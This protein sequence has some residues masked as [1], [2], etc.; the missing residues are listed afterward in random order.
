MQLFFTQLGLKVMHL[1]ARLLDVLRYFPLRLKR[2]FRH[3]IAGLQQLMVPEKWRSRSI[4]FWWIELCLLLLDLLGLSEYY[5]GISSFLKWST[6]PLRPEELKYAQS[7]YG[8]SIRWER[9]RI[10]ERAWLGPRQFRLCYVSGFTVNSWGTMNPALLIHELMHIWQYQKIG[11]VYIPRALRAYHS[12]ENYNYGG[13]T[14]LKK[15]RNANGTIWSFNL[16]QQADLVA[17]YFRLLN[18]QQPIWGDAGLEQLSEYAY[19]VEQL[20]EE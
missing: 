5:E 9:V 17:D 2:L 19:F 16:E 14:A 15:V 3:P 8:S 13:W 20:K 10:D 12:E 6:R 18:G 1:F 11:L 7:I 4:L